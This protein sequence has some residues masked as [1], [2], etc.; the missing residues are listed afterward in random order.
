MIYGL[1]V[2][3]RFC[4]CNCLLGIGI[5]PVLKGNDYRNRVTLSGK[6]VKKNGPLCTSNF[7]V[8]ILVEGVKKENCYEYMYD[9]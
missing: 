7:Y 4:E 3:L 9:M 8:L 2:L 6:I 5:P 1:K